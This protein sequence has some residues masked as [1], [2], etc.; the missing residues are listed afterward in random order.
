[1]VLACDRHEPAK[2]AGIG[3]YWVMLVDPRREVVDDP[4]AL[5]LGRRV[6]RHQRLR[7]LPDD[8]GAHPAHQ[9]RSEEH[10]SELQSRENLVCRLLLEKKTDQRRSPDG[11]PER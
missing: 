9:E 8:D 1:M 2:L 6:E 4:S 3:R 11:Q 5:A 7:V 10:T